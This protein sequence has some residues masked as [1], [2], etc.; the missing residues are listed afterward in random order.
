MK[1]KLAATIALAGVVIY[2]LVM[3]LF[4]GVTAISYYGNLGF[5]PGWMHISLI[6]PCCSSVILCVPLA[7]FLFAFMSKADKLDP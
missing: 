4:Y 2:M 6:C 1:L 7:A 5:P 3:G